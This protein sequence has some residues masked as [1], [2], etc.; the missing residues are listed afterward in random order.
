MGTLARNGLID[1]RK[2][3]IPLVVQSS[4]RLYYSKVVAVHI[5]EGHISVFRV[6]MI[7]LSK[8]SPVFAH[9]L[10]ELP[11]SFLIVLS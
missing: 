5:T 11:A 1:F 4:G 3:C 7:L 2:N 10:S 8:L 6:K 9:F